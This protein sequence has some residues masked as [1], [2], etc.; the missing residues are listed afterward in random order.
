MH[1]APVGAVVLGLGRT[2]FS[3]STRKSLSLVKERSKS[4]GST[5]CFSVALVILSWYLRSRRRRGCYTSYSWSLLPQNSMFLYSRL[6][7]AANTVLKLMSAV[8]AIAHVLFVS[9]KSLSV[10]IMPLEY[11][12]GKLK[13]DYTTLPMSGFLEFL[14]VSPSRSPFLVL[15]S[16]FS[17]YSFSLIKSYLT[18]QDKII[19]LRPRQS[20]TE[21]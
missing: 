2:F 4:S 16:I 14:L 10:G 5:C 8:I 13:Y 9:I 3:L 11:S 6:K 18:S 1:T 20:H 7:S 19:H 21:F 15:I 12:F 17:Y